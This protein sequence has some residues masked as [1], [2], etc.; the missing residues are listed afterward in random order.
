VIVFAGGTDSGATIASGGTEIISAGGTGVVTTSIGAG[1]TLETMSGGTAIVSG[2]V[3]NSGTL[4]ARGAG[5]LVEIASGAVVDG[6]VV[7]I[8]N[9]IVDVLAG[10]SARVAF[11]STGS[12]G[13]EIA[14]TQGS[15]SAFSGV[16]SGFGGASHTNHAQFVDLIGVTFNSGQITSSY[17]SASGSGT[18]TV[19]SG[20]HAVAA[21]EFVGNYS[22]GNFHITAGVSGSVKITDPGVVNGGSVENGNAQTFPQHGIDL[23]DI[24]FGAEMTLAYSQNRAETGGTLAAIDGRHAATLALLGNYMAGSFAATPDGHGGALVIDA[25]AGPAPLLTHPRA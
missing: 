25:Q 2:T 6:G 13:L 11:L 20:G 7:K 22:A 8:G 14:D 15:T 16:V 10:G 1:G 21:V 4:I 3:V 17:V 9:G 18:L 23:P 19:S 12:G 24:A 5:S